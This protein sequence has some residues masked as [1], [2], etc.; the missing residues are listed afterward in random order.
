M[1]THAVFL[2]HQHLNWTPIGPLPPSFHTQTTNLGPGGSVC[3][4]THNP[5]PTHEQTNTCAH[6]VFLYCQHLNR[7]P[8]DPLLSLFRTWTTN[9]GL[10]AQAHTKPSPTRKCTNGCTHPTFLYGQHVNWTPSTLSHHHLTITTWCVPLFH[11]Y[12][13]SWNR[14][15]VARIY[16][17]NVYILINMNISNENKGMS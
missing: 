6:P 16:I 2:Y 12:C 3:T 1:C 17:L 14:A 15:L 7:T 9:L 5:S 10:F 13:T 8:I 11:I 4:G